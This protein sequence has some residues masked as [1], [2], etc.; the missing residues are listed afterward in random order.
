[1]VP[2]KRNRSTHFI[3]DTGKAIHL[4]GIQPV[5]AT[6]VCVCSI[7]RGCFHLQHRLK[8]IRGLGKIHSGVVNV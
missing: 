1:M 5:I 6:A 8:H 3:P 4:T 7:L 2:D